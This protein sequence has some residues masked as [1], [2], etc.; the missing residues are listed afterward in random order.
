MD[1]CILFPSR[2]ISV[3]LIPTLIKDFLLLR[4]TQMW[5][6]KETHRLVMKLREDSDLSSV[7]RGCLHFI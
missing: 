7:K 1:T 5:L 3:L 6:F 2:A 4:S